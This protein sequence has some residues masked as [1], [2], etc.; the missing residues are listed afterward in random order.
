MDRAHMSTSIQT[1]PD[2]IS[3]QDVADVMGEKT[4]ELDF[5]IWHPLDH[6]WWEFSFCRQYHGW[7][8]NHLELVWEYGQGITAVREWWH[9][10]IGCR[11]GRH[12]VT[13][14]WRGWTPGTFPEPEPT[15]YMRLNCSHRQDGPSH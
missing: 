10:Q 7:T 1:M 5:S 11:W 9:R 8:R 6:H 12:Q 14:Y 13:P 3:E 4:P 2:P 15:G